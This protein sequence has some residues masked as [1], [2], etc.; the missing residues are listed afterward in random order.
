M[1]IS[2]TW[3]NSCSVKRSFS[4]H[5]TFLI[6]LSAQPYLKDMLAALRPQ[7]KEESILIVHIK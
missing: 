5:L 6:G 4:V 2:V 1:D 3:R 7:I